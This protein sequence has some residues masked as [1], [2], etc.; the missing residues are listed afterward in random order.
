MD[1]RIKYKIAYKIQIFL[2]L[3]LVSWS[4]RK[5]LIC[6][7]AL[8]D[9]H[10]SS[11]CAYMYVCSFISMQLQRGYINTYIRWPQYV[12]VIVHC[13]Y[14]HTYEHPLLTDTPIHFVSFTSHCR[15]AVFVS[16]TV[17]YVHVWCVFLYVCMHLFIY[18]CFLFFFLSYSSLY[19]FY[20][21]ICNT[22]IHF[23]ILNLHA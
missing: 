9:F 14:L 1:N 12:D 22:Y 15:S 8:V 4:K 11:V 20:I 16:S 2:V 7:L 23:C 18:L 17:C 10:Y 13:A 6:L 19:I 3:T 5:L 21:Y